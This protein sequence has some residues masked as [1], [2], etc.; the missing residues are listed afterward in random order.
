MSSLAPLPTFA[1]LP[2][3]IQGN[4]MSRC[5]R[6]QRFLT[7]MHV[8]KQWRDLELKC[9]DLWSV[10]VVVSRKPTAALLAD[11]SSRL[12][13]I[14]E[15]RRPAAWRTDGTRGR[16][17]RR[18][19]LHYVLGPHHGA[20][21]LL[22]SELGC[23]PDRSWVRALFVPDDHDVLTG[24]A[25]E[26]LRALC[27][28]VFTELRELRLPLHQLLRTAPSGGSKSH[29]LEPRVRERLVGWLQ[30]LRKL[31][32]VDLTSAEFITAFSLDRTFVSDAIAL[33]SLARLRGCAQ[34]GL[35][36]EHAWPER[37]RDR[38]TGLEVA[39]L[40]LSTR[41]IQPGV[42]VELLEQHPGLRRLAWRFA[43]GGAKD[44]RSVASAIA[45]AGALQAC[46][47]QP[48]PAR[49]WR[50]ACS[51]DHRRCTW[52]WRAWT[53]SPWMS[54]RAAF[55]TCRV[56]SLSSRWSTTTAGSRAACGQRR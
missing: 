3:E 34:L 55:A 49:T 7:H 10:I 47:S 35:A 5:E 2:S 46:A 23:I 27:A 17:E 6:W 8:C 37:W 9:S 32:Y 13:L 15:S 42:V 33:H 4:I 21:P 36:L 14:E 25:V 30:R 28:S 29:L 51:C 44:L 45:R 12:P 24:G 31:E 18:A 48:M 40:R 41:V 56:T 43:S 20:V 50:D 26:P 39:R 52:T 19:A 53:R 11:P 54:G 16:I 1:E 22:F 38:D